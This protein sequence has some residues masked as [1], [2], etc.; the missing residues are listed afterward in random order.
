[1]AEI[2]SLYGADIHQK[3]ANP[4]TVAFLEAL[5]EKA[6]SGEIIGVAASILHDDF[7]ASCAVVGGVGSY[8]MLG[9]LEMAR[10]DLV[11]INRSDDS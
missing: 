3:Q 4:D 5:L 6:R 7:T 8:S 10:Q 9:A 11:E 1:M 2:R